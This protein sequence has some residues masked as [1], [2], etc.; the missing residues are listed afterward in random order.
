[1]DAYIGSFFLYKGWG[2]KTPMLHYIEETRG[3]YSFT[4]RSFTSTHTKNLVFEDKGFKITKR[5]PAQQDKMQTGAWEPPPPTAGD[6]E[7]QRTPRSERAVLGLSLPAVNHF[8]QPAHRL[9]GRTTWQRRA[10]ELWQKLRKASRTEV[11]EGPPS[12][13]SITRAIMAAM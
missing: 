2:Q 13:P 9:W 5:T 1:M 7:V 4:R 6:L 11:E 12:G 8:H 10:T 3:G